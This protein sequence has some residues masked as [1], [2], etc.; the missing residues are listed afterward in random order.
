MQLELEAPLGYVSYLIRVWPR[1][2]E[3][4]I[5]CTVTLDSVATGRRTTLHSLDDLPAFF[6]SQFEDAPGDEKR[7]EATGNGTGGVKSDAASE[8]AGST[9]VEGTGDT[10]RD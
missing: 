1:S 7:A 3:G 2:V 10:K 6:R 5:D 4:H 8:A 9:A